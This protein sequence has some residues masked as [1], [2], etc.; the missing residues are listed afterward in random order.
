MRARRI[1]VRSSLFVSFTTL[2]AAL[3]LGVAPAAQAMTNVVPNGDFEAA[4][5]GFQGSVVCDW[6]PLLPATIAWDATNPHSGLR[7]MQ[8]TG[9][10]PSIEVTTISNICIQ[11]GPGVHSASFWYRTTDQ[12]ANQVALGANWYANSTC[13]VF[14]TGLPAVNTLAPITDGAWHQV[15]GTF[16]FPATTGSALFDVFEGCNSCTSTLTVNFDDIDVETEPSAVDVSSFT[17][18][19]TRQGVVVRW[20]TGTEVDELGFNVYRERGSKRVV[21]N[22]RLLAAHGAVGGS[23][24]SFVDRRAPRLGAVRYWLQDVSTSG[25]RTWHGPVRIGRA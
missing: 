8:L 13:S 12:V 25:A 10:G 18:A 2:A 15:T 21:L 7:S 22:R 24:Y 11:I 19:R 5:C 6:N 9:L 14:S 17:A 20:R 16:T 23:S 4:P 3:L 1:P